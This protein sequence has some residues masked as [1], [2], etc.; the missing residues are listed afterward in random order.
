MIEFSCP[1]CGS[2]IKAQDAAAG[3]RGKCRHCAQIVEV[4]G[5]QSVRPQSAPREEGTPTPTGAKQMPGE[6]GSARSRPS[7]EPAVPRKQGMHEKDRPAGEPRRPPAE[8]EGV[9]TW[10][11]LTRYPIGDEDTLP[12]RLRRWMLYHFLGFF[13]TAFFGIGLLFTFLILGYV[14]ETLSAVLC[15]NEPDPPPWPKFWSGVARGL[16][17]ALLFFFCYLPLVIVGALFMET[18]MEPVA[19]TVSVIVLPLLVGLVWFP[20]LT[21]YAASGNV[22]E[23]CRLGPLVN[24]I[25]ANPAGF[26]KAFLIAI[27]TMIIAGFLVGMFAGFLVLY[28]VLRFLFTDEDDLPLAWECSTPTAMAVGC[29]RAVG[30]HFAAAYGIVLFL[31]V[32]SCLIWVLIFPA[33]MLVMLTGLYWTYMVTAR[34]YAA[35]Y[36]GETI[37]IA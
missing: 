20:L 30:G 12:P 6:V 32:G 23:F 2:R 11:S 34:A 4:P 25:R 28:Y 14:I 33:C 21:H 13:L 31:V 3:K 29:W 19:V 5:S 22:R 35:A 37:K 7:A 8:G 10:K 27:L 17:G 36:R 26:L 24:A 9:V 18:K 16:F 1:H 15:R